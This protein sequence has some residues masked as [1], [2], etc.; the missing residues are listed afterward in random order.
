M[1]V[2][3]TLRGIVCG[4]AAAVC[5]G[6]NPLGALNLYAGGL[7]TGSVLAYRFSIA[8]VILGLIMFLSR[9]AFTVTRREL[10]ILAVLGMLFAV[11]SMSL[12]SS[13]HFMDAGIACTLLFVYPVMVALIMAAFFKERLTAVTCLSILLALSG[14]CLL[15]RGDS[16]MTLSLAG[17]SLVMLSSLTYALYIIIVNRSSLRM[18][19]VK[20][21]FY[22]MLICA[23]SIIIYTLLGDSHCIEPLTSAAMW[24]YALLLGLI[25]TVFSLVLMVM[26]VH[27]IGSTPTAIMGA[28]EPLTAVVIGVTVFGEAFTPRLAAGILLI[29]VAVVLIISG[30]SLPARKV[31]YVAGRLG[32]LLKK[33]WRWK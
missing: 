19:S 18:S 14:I 8:V 4:V 22:V 2:N 21:S 25:P 29:F 5:Y 31:T 3:K 32:Q 17:V 13:F 26:A 15:Y 30:K 11:S 9:K 16:G 33:T 12:Y 7:S 10:L 28:L 6:L 24:G 1:I 27:D 20:L 23:L